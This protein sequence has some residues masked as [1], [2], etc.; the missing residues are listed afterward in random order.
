MKN[1]E[2]I[3]DELYES[4]LTWHYDSYFSG[5][6]KGKRVLELGVG[7]GKTLRALIKKSPNEIIAVDFSDKAVNESKILES[8]KVKVIKADITSLPFEDKF[9]VIVC[10]YVLNNMLEKDRKLAVK[11]MRRLLAKNGRIYFEDFAIGDLRQEKEKRIE[12]NTFLKENGLICHF[13]DEKEIRKLFRG[14]DIKIKTES[15]KP[16][17]TINAKRRIMKA[18]IG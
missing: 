4:K 3:W 1:Q 10:N 7:T 14:F 18:E 6:I 11:E 2:R 15:F 17:R 8:Y 16:F 13:F 9:E 12:R 5:E